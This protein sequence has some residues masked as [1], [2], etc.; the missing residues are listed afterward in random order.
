MLARL[1]LMDTYKNSHKS[2]IIRS[3][4]AEIIRSELPPSRVSQNTPG[5]HPQ[6]EQGMQLCHGPAEFFLG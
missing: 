1:Y 3:L 5:I 2:I 4:H 6:A